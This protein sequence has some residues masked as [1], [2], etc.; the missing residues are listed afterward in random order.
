MLY[1]FELNIQKANKYLKEGKY[2]S[3]SK[4]LIIRVYKEIREVY[5]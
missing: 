1:L 3:V 2:T 5:I 4:N